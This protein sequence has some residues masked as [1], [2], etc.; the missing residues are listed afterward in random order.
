MG[1]PGWLELHAGWGP[2]GSSCRA[3]GLWGA[4]LEDGVLAEGRPV[5]WGWPRSTS[6]TP[7][8]YGLGRGLLHLGK[9]TSFILGSAEEPPGDWRVTPGLGRAGCLSVAGAARSTAG[10]WDAAPVG[11]GTT[12]F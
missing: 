10:A 5:G 2:G 4:L 12:F 9:Q 8:E 1:P 6:V 3:V 7:R 11:L